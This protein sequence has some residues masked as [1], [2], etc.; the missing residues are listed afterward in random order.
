MLYHGF[1]HLAWF[2]DTDDISEYYE[3]RSAKT[4]CTVSAEDDQPQK[5]LD[6][7]SQ[8]NS[9]V[10]STHYHVSS[11]RNFPSYPL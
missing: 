3:L 9:T 1:G 10:D 5:L 2:S 8:F 11:Q 4:S 6:E 7:T